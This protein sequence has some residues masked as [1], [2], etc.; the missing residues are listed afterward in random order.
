MNNCKYMF[1]DFI[2]DLRLGREFDLI[3][4]REKYGVSNFNGGKISFAKYGDKSFCQY[5]NNYYEFKQNS[6]IE[7]ELLGDIWEEHV[8]VDIMY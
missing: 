1:E 4:Y 3:I 6:K 7:N 2:L 5:F 8:E